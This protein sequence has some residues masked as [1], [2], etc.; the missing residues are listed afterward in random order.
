METKGANGADY[1]KST[2]IVLMVAFGVFFSVG[3]DIALA[4]PEADPVKTASACRIDTPLKID[5]YLIEKV[6]DTA[7][8]MDG[9]RQVEPDDGAPASE[10]TVFAVLY[11]DAAVYVGVWCADSE[12]EKISRQLTRRDRW[13]ESDQIAV[14]ID[15]YHDHQTAYYFSVNAAGIQRDILLFNNDCSDDS[16]D[17]VWE[18]EAKITEAGWTAEY[19]IPYSALRFSEAPDYIWGFDLTRYIPRHNESSRWQYVPRHE[20][21]G[22]SRYG[23]LVGI[24]DIAPPGRIE[25]LPYLVSYGRT[26]PRSRGNLEGRDYISNMGVDLKYGLSTWLTLDATINPD[27]GQVESDQSVINLTAYETFYDEKRPFF[28]EGMEIFR[29]P[30]F[31]QF[32]SRRIGRSPT[33]EFSEAAYYEDYPTRTTILSAVKLTGKTAGGTSIGVLNAVTQEEEAA[34]RV[35]GDNRTHRGVVEPPA[36]YSVVRLKQ[37]IYG[38]SYVGGLFTLANQRERTDAVTGSADWRLYFNGNMYHFSGSMIAT[39]N[40]PDTEDVA[41]AASFGK[42]SG[43]II[44][45]N[46]GV[47]YYGDK[48]DWNR[49]G[50][51]ER[52]GTRGISSWIQFYSNERFHFIRSMNIN[53]N[54]WYNELLDGHRN[55][56]GGNIN[57]YVQLTNNWGFWAGVGRDFSRYHD[58]ETRGKGLWWVDDNHRWW[59]GFGTNQAKKVSL[60]VEH[61]QDNERDGRFYLYNVWLNFRFLANFQ[62]SLGS[63]YLINRGVDFWVGEGED[64]RPV[65]GKLDNNELDINFRG[66][67]TFSKRTTLQWY[68][69]LYFSTGEYDRFRR[70]TTPETLEEFDESQYEVDFHRND[71]NYKSIN[72]NLI[73]RWEYLPGSTLFLVWT[74]ARDAYITDYGDFRISRDFPDLFEI[75]QTNTFL[76]KANYWWNI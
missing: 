19:R 12:P 5:G 20:P 25:T 76:I 37:D 6:W 40:G 60:E 75:P 36:N 16:W 46:I 67:Y 3:V 71:F 9:F 56:T 38:S 31:Y 65:F 72:L 53:F 2:I 4:R 45:G 69:Q 27:F 68:T 63:E 29:T 26:Q 51:M 18:A 8:R 13:T 48:V 1:M 74:H 41:A 55:A 54:G 70:L 39:R 34:Y 32:Y 33:A 64:G 59:A 42:N 35:D 10:P 15:S 7:P 44:R 61:H 49:L 66:I 73:L 50:Y 24:K 14:R 23:H 22:V 62:I 52:N 17:A 11:D 30:F 57:G 58:R 28:L 47:D 43:K 21:G